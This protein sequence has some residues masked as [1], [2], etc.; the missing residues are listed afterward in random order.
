MNIQL[1]FCPIC[2][3]RFISGSGQPLPN[4]RKIKASLSGEFTT[5]LAIC[6]NCPID[7]ETLSGVWEITKD[8]LIAENPNLGEVYR[9]VTFV[10]IQS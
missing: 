6:T 10:K 2:A 1:G 9:N 8:Y 5:D 7:E 3:Q 4:Y